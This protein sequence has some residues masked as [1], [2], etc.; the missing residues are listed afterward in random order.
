MLLPLALLP[1]AGEE[2]DAPAAEAAV[3]ERGDSSELANRP[4]GREEEETVVVEEEAAGTE[5]ELEL[6]KVAVV[7]L[8]RAE[9]C[10]MAR[11]D[12]EPPTGTDVGDDEDEE[13]DVLT[14]WS[15]ATAAAAAESSKRIW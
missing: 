3:D 8:S 13:N 1:M 7:A 4:K 6:D 2:A 10:D 5:P 14:R 12:A 15:R 11:A 9:A